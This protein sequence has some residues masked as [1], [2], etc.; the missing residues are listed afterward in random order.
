MWGKFMYEWQLVL[1]LK[2]AKHA[3]KDKTKDELTDIASTKIKPRSDTK[4]K[5]AF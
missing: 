4:N 3:G 1:K 2:R 5:I